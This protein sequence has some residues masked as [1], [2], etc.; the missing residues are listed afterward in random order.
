MIAAQVQ[1]SAAVVLASDGEGGAALF[2]LVL[3]A[4]PFVIGWFV[5]T[6]LYRRY[7]NQNARYLF[8]HT[9]SAKR[10]NLQ[11]WDTFTRAKNRQRSSK[12]DGRNDDE[13]LERTAHSVV[14]EAMEPRQAQEERVAQEARLA[15]EAREAQGAREGAPERQ[16]D[17]PRTEPPTPSAGGG[18]QGPSV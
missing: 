1:G 8:E 5:Y 10:S 3:F 11:R 2:G 9:T 13:P 14:R 15:Q 16:A 6:T 17:A 18:Q 4:A 12:I 7:R